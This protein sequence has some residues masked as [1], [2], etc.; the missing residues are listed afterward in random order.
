MRD[1]MPDYK[2][3]SS[4]PS[5]I[6][7]SP[8]VTY[9]IRKLLRQNLDCLQ[10]VVAEG[11]GIKADALSDLNRVLESLYVDNES[12]NAALLKL[13]KLV[14][15]HQALSAREIIHRPE[16][17]NLE[18]EIFWLL[19]FKPKA[20]KQQGKLLLVDD[21]LANLQLLSAALGQRGYEVHS[22]VNGVLALKEARQIIP[23]LILLDV[24]MPGMNG[25]EVCEQLKANTLTQDIP[26]IFISAVNEL[27][28]KVKA[29]QL[30]G[31][32]YITK[33]F[34]IDEVIARVEN[35]L[36]VRSLQKRLETQNVRLQ[37]EIRERKRAEEEALET[38]AHTKEFDELKSRFIS[39]VSKEF[40]APL[41]TIQA[42]LVGLK[43]QIEWGEL[44][45]QSIQPIEASAQ[46]M[47]LLLD[48][49]LFLEKVRMNCL[50]LSPT[51]FDFK[52]FCEALTT[53][54]QLMVGDRYPLQA[55]YKNLPAEVYLDQQILRQ[56]LYN[57]LSNAVK[58][59]PNGGS[60]SLKVDYH[61][62]HLGIEV[63]D[64]G[65]GIP[66][67]DQNHLFEVFHRAGNASHIPG[68]G[69]GLAIVKQCVELQNGSVS[70]ESTVGRG[71]RFR[72][73]LPV[74][75]PVK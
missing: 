54:I 62:P 51:W 37:Q 11:A 60:I 75:G 55:L 7:L 49:L 74:H 52:K 13:E 21:T 29:F 67:V 16:L 5:Q 42:S 3:N 39:I 34:Q 28:D 47:M 45:G 71:S 1:D 2:A 46:H 15:S 24:M 32:D 26:I 17:H 56:I 44:E 66:T 19:G 31:V 4:P 20:P 43:T 38:L 9:Y 53:E 73:I 58:Y 61:P 63:E 35:Q 68:T 41:A 30:G 72:V 6:F 59:S 8:I 48:N 64:Q 70:V 33:P 69:L 65:L 12:I 10:S 23:D 14:I 25:Y 27:L 18:Q 36:S 57:L 50:E 40:Q 22:A